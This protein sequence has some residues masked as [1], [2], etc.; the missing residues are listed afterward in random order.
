MCDAY[1]AT[2][3]QQ[4]EFLNMG[5]CIRYMSTLILPGGFHLCNPKYIYRL[6]LHE[7]SACICVFRMILTVNNDLFPQTAVA[8][9]FQPTH[10]PDAVIIA[11]LFTGVEY[12]N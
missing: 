12:S 9:F 8:C 4:G 5:E 1:V 7:T 11:A 10:A 3:G 2:S 6:L